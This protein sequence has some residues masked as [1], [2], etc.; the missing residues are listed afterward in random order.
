MKWDS[1]PVI[2]ATTWENSHTEKAQRPPPGAGRVLRSGTTSFITP[3]SY[4][5][6]AEDAEPIPLHQQP[7]SQEVVA[8][9]GVEGTEAVRERTY[10]ERME[11][12]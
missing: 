8:G 11:R 12:R 2:L 4:H 7:L 3:S 5:A 1:G 10:V 6:L 9:E